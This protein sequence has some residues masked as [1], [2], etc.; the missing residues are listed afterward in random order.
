MP[1]HFGTFQET[2]RTVGYISARLL[3]LFITWLGTFAL[4]LECFDK[5]QTATLQNYKQK[6]FS[7]SFWVQKIWSSSPTAPSQLTSCRLSKSS[8]CLMISTT[9]NSSCILLCDIYF[10]NTAVKAVEVNIIVWKPVACPSTKKLK[11]CDI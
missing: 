7:A 10:I 2:A 3:A 11:S 5:I 6:L 4:V 9:C 8:S 1:R